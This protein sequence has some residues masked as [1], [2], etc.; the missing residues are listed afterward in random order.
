MSELTGPRLIEIRKVLGLSQ[1]ALA[2]RS[3]VNKAYI[4]EYETEIRT[5]PADSV[6]RIKAALMPIATAAGHTEPRVKRLGGGDPRLVLLTG[7]GELALPEVVVVLWI[8]GDGTKQRLFV[9]NR[10][11]GRQRDAT[12]ERNDRS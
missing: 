8:D 12:A 2:L 9:G 1:Q 5:L 7:A 10:K 6:A 11:L 4:S 3:G